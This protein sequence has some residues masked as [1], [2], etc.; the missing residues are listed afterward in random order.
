MAGMEE[1]LDRNFKRRDELN[2]KM[3][4]MRTAIAAA[5]QQVC[6]C[7]CVWCVCVCVVCVC[8]C[9]GGWVGWCGWMVAG[10]MYIYKFVHACVHACLRECTYIRMCMNMFQKFALAFLYGPCVG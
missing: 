7:V 6:T 1:E 3:E 5:T 10:M 4:E 8:V 9:V 2:K